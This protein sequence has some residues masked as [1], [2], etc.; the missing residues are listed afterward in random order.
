MDVLDKLH[1]RLY[2]N[3]LKWWNKLADG[4]VLVIKENQ[5]YKFK[6]ASKMPELKLDPNVKAILV[7][8]Q[9]SDNLVHF[10]NHIMSRHPVDIALVMLATKRPMDVIVPY[11]NKFFRKVGNKEYTLRGQQSLSKK[12][13]IDKFNVE[14]M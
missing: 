10:V 12:K 2:K 13:L 6:S 1:G 14:K 11:Y 5:E 4:K 9:S 7:S 8:G 3:N